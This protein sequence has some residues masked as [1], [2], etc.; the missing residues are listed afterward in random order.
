[1]VV[2]TQARVA[3]GDDIGEALSAVATAVLIGERPGLSSPDSLGIYLTWN[4]RRGLTDADRNCI[5]NIHAQGMLPEHAAAK[6]AALLN[7]ARAL[8]ASG[9]LLHD[10]MDDSG[11]AGLPFPL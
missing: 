6:L 8:G 3:L 5:S 11:K 9:T 1:V 7:G 2:A 4:P 10:E